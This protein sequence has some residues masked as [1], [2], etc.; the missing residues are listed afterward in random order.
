MHHQQQLLT[1]TFVGNNINFNLKKITINMT[2]LRCNFSSTTRW[3]LNQGAN[4]IEIDLTLEGSRPSVFCHGFPCDCTCLLQFLINRHNRCGA[5]A[6]GC[7]AS[8]NVTEMADFLGSSEVV[9]SRLAL[10]Y[11]DAKLDKSVRNYAEAGA[12]VVRLFNERVFARGSAVK[13]FLVV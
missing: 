7:S 2:Q 9:S 12:N 1:T 8:T 4:G 10:I 5:L 11:I 6:E 13:F 3:A